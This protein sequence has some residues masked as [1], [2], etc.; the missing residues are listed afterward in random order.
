MTAPQIK[1]IS[2]DDHGFDAADLDPADPAGVVEHPRARTGSARGRQISPRRVRDLISLS[3]RL[4]YISPNDQL[5]EHELMELFSTSRTSVR[6]ALAQLSENGMIERRPRAGTKVRSIGLTIP[7]ADIAAVD[8]DVYL[9]IIEDRIVPNF[10][11]AQDRLRLDSDRVR[12][13]EN[14][15]EYQ[16]RPIGIRT[17][18]FS[19]D[20]D[21]N[22]VELVTGAPLHMVTIMGEAFR[23]RPGEADVIVGVDVADARDARLLRIPVG[24]PLVVREMTYHADNG[25]PIEIVFDRFRGDLVHISGTAEV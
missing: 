12:M 18:Y 17:A 11:L 25:D 23:A 7:L 24:R 6:T 13:V 4:G 5:V 9:R 15:F 8:H 16:G 20:L 10:P 2:P 21:L 19:K 14:T 3:I 1:G 22:P